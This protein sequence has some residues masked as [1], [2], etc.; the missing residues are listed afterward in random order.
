MKK[1]ILLGG[2]VCLLANFSANASEYPQGSDVNRRASVYRYWNQFQ[3]N[4]DTPNREQ[5]RKEARDNGHH[6]AYGKNPRHHKEGW[7]KRPKHN[8]KSYGDKRLRDPD[9]K[10]DKSGD[11]YPENNR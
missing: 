10:F 3:I 9:K 11:R 8:G 4:Q 1:I 5:V 6:Y 2:A 7:K